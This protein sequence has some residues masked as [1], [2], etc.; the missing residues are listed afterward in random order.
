MYLFHEPTRFPRDGVDVEAWRLSR[1][2]DRSLVQ[3]VGCLA[4]LKG[5]R[6][7]SSGG[8]PDESVRR[9]LVPK[10]DRRTAE[11]HAPAGG[12]QRRYGWSEKGKG[13]L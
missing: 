3:C 6:C 12:G 8:V 11:Q 4:S 1:V 7:R 13:A 10:G 2:Q 5:A 9:A